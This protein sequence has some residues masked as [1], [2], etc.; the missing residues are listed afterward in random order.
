MK[1]AYRFI[2]SHEVDSVRSIIE[3]V[4]YRHI[5]TKVSLFVWRLLRNR[6]PTR[7]NLLQ[8]IYFNLIIISAWLVVI[9]QKQQD[10]FFYHVVNQIFYGHWYWPG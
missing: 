6:L 5:P 7:D 3:N 1:E 10:I 4:W 2:A 9:V 8:K